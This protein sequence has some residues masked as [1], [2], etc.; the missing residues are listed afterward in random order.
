MIQLNIIIV[1][2]VFKQINSFIFMS[3]TSCNTF[4]NFF[5]YISISS[6]G[7][8]TSVCIQYSQFFLLVFS[9]HM[10]LPE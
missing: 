1:A 8:L 6:Y 7:T 4:G 2:H 5:F 10:G 3:T 9:D